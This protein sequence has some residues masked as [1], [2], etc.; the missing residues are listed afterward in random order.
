MVLEGK[1]L[2]KTWETLD[3]QEGVLEPG[4]RSFR[5]VLN[6]L[7]MLANAG[8]KKVMAWMGYVARCNGAYPMAQAA[9]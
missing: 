4:L 5:N 2:Q 3:F 7:G 6:Q 8:E 9:A 1:S